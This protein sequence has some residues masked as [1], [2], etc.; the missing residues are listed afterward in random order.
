[1]KP[2]AISLRADEALKIAI[3]EIRIILSTEVESKRKIL[4]HSCSYSTIEDENIA[5]KRIAEIGFSPEE[6]PRNAIIGW[7]RIAEIKTY[8]AA[9]FAIDGNLHGHGIDLND[10]ITQQGWQGQTVYGYFLEDHHILKIPV[11]GIGTE[12]EHGDAWEA[13]S[14]FQLVCFE[15]ALNTESIDIANTV[16]Y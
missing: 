10:F 12:Y 3:G 9:T 6:V 8:N 13:V 11:M 4:I 2:I 16:G 1:M 14:P 5:Y 7:A 15:R